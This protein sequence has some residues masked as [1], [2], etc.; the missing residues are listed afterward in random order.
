MQPRCDHIV[1]GTFAK[2]RRPSKSTLRAAML[3]TSS[4]RTLAERIYA[5]EIGEANT[6][7]EAV[8][9]VQRIQRKLAGAMSPVIGE[10]GVRAIVR[11]SA[12]KAQLTHPCLEAI[13]GLT[14]DAFIEGLG[15]CLREEGLAA[16][17]PIGV[18]LFVGF[19]ALMST[20][21]GSDL[22][23]RPLLSTW[24]EAVIHAIATAEKS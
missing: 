18:D 8:A 6:A 22:A 24:P 12:Q 3:G 5:E 14:D 20:F 17:R 4:A 21:I 19:L 1:R 2:P 13:V 7:E 11:R 10:A 9:A 16:I 15:S 23:L